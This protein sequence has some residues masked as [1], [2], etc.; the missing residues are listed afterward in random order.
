MPSAE[1]FMDKLNFI[2]S[3]ARWIG[4]IAIAIF[5]FFFG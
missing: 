4:D 3:V 1:N 5:E 2:V